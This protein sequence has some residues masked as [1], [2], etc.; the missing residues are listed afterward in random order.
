MLLSDRVTGSV[1]VRLEAMPWEQALDVVLASQGLGRHESAGMIIVEP[2]A[3][4]KN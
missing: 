4:L 3:S 1:T 2:L